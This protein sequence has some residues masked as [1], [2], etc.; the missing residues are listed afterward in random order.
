MVWALRSP[1]AKAAGLTGWAALAPDLR[2][3]V[4][5]RG[6]ASTRARLKRQH[7]SR[8]SNPGWILGFKSLIP[9]L[10]DSLRWASFIICTRGNL[11]QQPTPLRSGF[12]KCSPKMG[13]QIPLFFYFFLLITNPH[14]KTLHPK[15]THKQTNKQTKQKKWSKSQLT[16]KN[17]FWFC[18][19]FC[20]HVF[21]TL[22]CEVPK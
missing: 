6:P 4:S 15:D 19:V 8:R 1:W 9:H 2:P 3:G 5:P 12:A 17:F 10:K 18:V 22:L 7:C 20:D 11:S 13:I 14:H 16:K 21:N